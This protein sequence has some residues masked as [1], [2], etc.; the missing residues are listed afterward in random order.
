MGR[1]PEDGVILMA[2]D[3]QG[4]DEVVRDEDVA[5]D[6]RAEGAAWDE[7]AGA[8]RDEA[9]EEA[10][11]G[12]LDAE[13]ILGRTVLYALEQGAEKLEQNGGFEPFTIL[14]EGEELYIEEQPGE[15]E[16]QSYAAARRTV[17]QMERLC[18]AY[19]FCYDGF[20]DLEEGTSDALVAEYASK[21]D[22]KA[23]VIVRLY[24]RHGDHYH[25]DEVL[26]QVGEA[27]TLFSAGAGGAGGAG[28]AAAGAA[29]AAGSATAGSKAGAT[30]GGVSLAAGEAAITTADAALGSVM[31]DDVTSD[32]LAEAVAAVGEAATAVV[33]G[34][35]ESSL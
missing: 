25:F 23:Q 31:L 24:H 26:Y 4:V 6:E 21:G 8:V 22:E 12:E 33:S 30:A 2:R 15:T 16:E 13:G 34:I 28:A 5:R 19:V 9:A 10:A 35:V 18:N 32:P 3:E 20:V 1:I 11:Q 17:Y 7:D 27:D 14:I 29:A